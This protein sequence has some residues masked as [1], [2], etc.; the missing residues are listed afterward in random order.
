MDLVLFVLE[1]KYVEPMGL[2]GIENL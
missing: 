2:G 1:P